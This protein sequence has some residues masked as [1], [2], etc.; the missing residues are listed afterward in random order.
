MLTVKFWHLILS[1]MSMITNQSWLIFN[2]K[3]IDFLVKVLLASSEW[4]N[5]CVAFERM[6]SVSKDISFNKA[7][8]KQYSKWVIPLVFLLTTLT[9]IHDPIYRQLIYD[10]DADEQRIWCFVQYSPSV[11]SYNVF[12][13]LFH[14][15]VPFSINLI[16]AL[17]VIKKIA[18]RRAIIQ[19]EQPY[20]Q[21][22]QRQLHRHRHILV[23]PCILILLS[24]PRL[25]I[26]FMKGCMRSAREPWFHLIG[27]FVSFIPSMLTFVVFVLPSKHYKKEF[28]TMYEGTIRR[29]R[30]RF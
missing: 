23:A 13:T 7:K 11:R 16:T 4:L 15:L 30:R 14:F 2:C 26:S 17:R 1:Q 5:A 22:L 27:Y 8:S 18:R 9:Q 20:K 25:V 21:H 3:L 12:I 24:F 29:F 28:R 10:S 6:I 19:P